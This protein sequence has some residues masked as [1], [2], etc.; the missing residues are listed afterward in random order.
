M[1]VYPWVT[2]GLRGPITP[3][4]LS[5]LFPADALLHHL[6]TLLLISGSCL[7]GYLEIGAVVFVLHD[8]SS[9]VLK[10]SSC[11]TPPPFSLSLS[12][13][14]SWSLF[15]SPL[16]SYLVTLWPCA[17]VARACV[18]TRWRQRIGREWTGIHE[19]FKSALSRVRGNLFPV[20]GHCLSLFGAR[21]CRF[22]HGKWTDRRHR[23]LFLPL[24]PL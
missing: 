3:S 24:L 1:M 12:L 6:V 23:A 9:I 14:L 4:R 2:A 15:H 22:R 19:S 17:P 11:Y 7:G 5:E 8:T 20:A 21:G 18:Q 13:S 10:V 16:F